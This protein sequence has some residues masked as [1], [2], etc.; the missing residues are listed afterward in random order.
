MTEVVVVAVSE[1]VVIAGAGS[2]ETI[3]VDVAAD[4]EV[5]EVA[6]QGLPG[7]PGPAGGATVD[8][9][10]VAPLS[11]LRVVWEDTAGSVRPLDYRDAAHIDRIAGVTVTAAGD[12]GSLVAVQRAGPLDAAG[13][14]LTPGRVWLG[15]DGA[16]TQVTPVDGF[17]VLIGYATDTTRLYVDIQ[18]NVQLED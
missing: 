12:A 7:P 10:A 18:D 13:L 14:G 5:V 3:V 1:T 16:L 11:A 8:R 2:N 17:D 6:E 4:I 15:V 9:I